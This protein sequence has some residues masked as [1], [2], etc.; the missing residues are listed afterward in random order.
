MYVIFENK[1]IKVKPYIKGEFKEKPTKTPEIKQYVG[2]GGL[3]FYSEKTYL[4]FE[5]EILMLRKRFMKYNREHSSKQ[6]KGLEKRIALL[7]EYWYTYRYKETR[8]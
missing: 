8:W 4:I 1:E 5:K 6:Q 3:C 2:V 7:K